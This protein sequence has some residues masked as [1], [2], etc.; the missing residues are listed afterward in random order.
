MWFEIFFTEV[1]VDRIHRVI[2]ELIN[3]EQ[4]GISN[5]GGDETF[6]SKS[7][8]EEAGLMGLEKAYD[9]FNLTGKCYVM[10]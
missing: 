9:R 6:E 4:E 2:N 10:Y 1:L 5:Q 7:T 8:R 3:K